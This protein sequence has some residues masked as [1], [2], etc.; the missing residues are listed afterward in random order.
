MGK[1]VSGAFQRWAFPVS[2]PELVSG[3]LRTSGATDSES[4]LAAEAVG[5][6]GTLA[7]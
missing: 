5:E 2:H 7:L 6:T 3:S 1:T 4:G